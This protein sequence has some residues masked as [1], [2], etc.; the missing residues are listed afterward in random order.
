MHVFAHWVEKLNTDGVFSEE[1]Y[2]GNFN[3]ENCIVSEDNAIE[4][5][6]ALEVHDYM[7]EDEAIDLIKKHCK[8]K[9]DEPELSYAEFKH[10]LYEYLVNEKATTFLELISEHF[11]IPCERITRFLR[12]LESEMSKSGPAQVKQFF[13]QEVKFALDKLCQHDIYDVSEHECKMKE[14]QSLK[15]KDTLGLKA[16]HNH[17]PR[18]SM[19]IPW[20]TQYSNIGADK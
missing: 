11:Q 13:K 20:M 9:E 14:D 18:Q 17:K 7:S 2:T 12:M 16:A 8:E 3:G 15:K 5:L 6:E 1:D 19:R 4:I 10:H